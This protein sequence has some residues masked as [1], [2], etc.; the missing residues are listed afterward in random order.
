MPLNP[1][2]KEFFA[3]L[4][5]EQ[6]AKPSSSTAPLTIEEFRNG[7]IFLTHPGKPADVEFID[8]T[9]TVRDGY[10][11]PIR[12]YNSDLKDTSPV[13]IFYPGCGYVLPLFEV[14]AIACSRI[15]AQLKIKVIVVDFRL[16]PE[17]PL[18]ISMYDAYD[19]TC[20]LASHAQEFG[21]DP[22]KIFIGGI[23]SGAH[24]AA[25]VAFLARDN[26]NLK[27]HH[28]IL[29]NGF[30]DLTQ[31]NHGYDDYEKED[32]LCV[33]NGLDFL[34]GQYGIESKDY[35]KPL[36]S[37]YYVT[38]FSRYPATTIIV[39]EYDG[40]RNDSEGYYKKLK[41]AGVEVNKIILPGQTHNTFIMREIMI[42]G[43]DPAEAIANVIKEKI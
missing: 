16:T 30:F 31:T 7:S 35:I 24:C 18:P 29:L 38:D 42:D 25:T 20:Y 33:R 2:E 6:A 10:E 32:Y 26:K 37:P 12:I 8:T 3:Q 5:A 9:I 14:N 23:S 13:L 27:I 22:N 40:I 1:V 36:Y 11:V 17:F 39:G 28:Q 41:S 4:V 19:V 34:L 21:V 15:A 43:T